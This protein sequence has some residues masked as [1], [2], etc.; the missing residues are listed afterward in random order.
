MIRLLLLVCTFIGAFVIIRYIFRL[1]FGYHRPPR[2][3]YYN[4][5]TQDHD[6]VDIKYNPKREKR[7][8]SN[9]GEY[10]DYEDINDDKK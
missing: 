2:D 3:R 4:G 8:D 1:L 10:V 6:D 9:M 7:F 5:R